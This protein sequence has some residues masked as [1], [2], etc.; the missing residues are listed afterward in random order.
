VIDSPVPIVESRVALVR[1]AFEGFSQGDIP[2]VLALL[3][4][5]VEMPDVI[6]GTVVRG[7]DEVERMWRSQFE[8]AEHIVIPGEILEMGDAV[9]V[10]GH[11]QIYGHG[12]GPLGPGVTVVHRVSFRGDRISRVEVTPLDEVPRVVQER[13]Q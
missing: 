5:D 9:I 7:K 6:H 1:R 4:A 3:H 13:L 2:G 10:V 12:D 11:H 8:R